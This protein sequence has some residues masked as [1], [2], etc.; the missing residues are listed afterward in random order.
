MTQTCLDFD[1]EQF[2]RE[3]VV[4]SESVIWFDILGLGI[5]REHSLRDLAE[6]QGLYRSHQVTFRY[7]RLV[8]NLLQNLNNMLSLL[9][10]R[11]NCIS[12][13]LRCCEGNLQKTLDR[14]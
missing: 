7:V 2:R 8:L 1:A 12:M 4:D 10:E 3:L 9:P 13:G 11:Q 14:Y 6:C 5:F